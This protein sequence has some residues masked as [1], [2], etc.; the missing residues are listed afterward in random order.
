MSKVTTRKPS[1]AWQK[2]PNTLVDS[3]GFMVPP[4]DRL[5]MRMNNLRLTKK[6]QAP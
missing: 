6:D 4:P 5:D 3:R 2:N 1:K